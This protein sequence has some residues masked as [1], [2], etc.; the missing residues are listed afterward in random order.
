MGRSIELDL[1][2]QMAPAANLRVQDENPV[3]PFMSGFW[4]NR[5]K[6]RLPVPHAVMGFGHDGPGGGIRFNLEAVRHLHG[7][8]ILADDPQAQCVGADNDFVGG[9]FNDEFGRRRAGLGLAN[10][11]PIAAIPLP[12][13]L[14]V[15]AENA[16]DVQGQ[17]AR[18]WTHLVRQS[19]EP[20]RG[21][22]GPGIEP[23]D[24]P[25]GRRHNCG[26]H[27]NRSRQQKP[28]LCSHPRHVSS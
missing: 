19:V 21:I 10:R 25:R 12:F 18:S 2:P 7:V 15:G 17:V 23:L 28:T 4:P 14:L 27:D 22:G 16:A 3:I 9:D 6:F 11:R 26:D 8:G 24:K 5:S 1:C 20:D 13:R